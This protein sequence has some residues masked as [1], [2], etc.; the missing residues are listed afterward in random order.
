MGGINARQG[1]EMRR[2]LFNPATGD[3]DVVF[4]SEE[5]SRH[6]S[7]VLRMLPGTEVELFDG[8]GTVFKAVILKTGSRVTARL[9]QC[10]GKKE[11]QLKPVWVAQGLLKGKKM[12]MVVQKC[13]ELGATRFTPFVSSRC[14]GKLVRVQSS[15]RLERWQ[16][17]TIAACKQCMRNQ[18]ML[19]DETLAFADL[20]EL[21]EVA[22]SPLRLLFW[23][24]ETVTRLDDLPSFAQFNSICLILGPE[25]GLTEEEVEMAKIKGWRTVTLGE[26]ILRA[27]TA[28]LSA[29]SIVQ[30]L[31]GNI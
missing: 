4:L 23:E 28:N 13:T 29:V 24:E 22:P 30:Y 1:Y 20:L 5:E 6:I 19:V 3:G 25:G 2:F 9:G 17:L 15:R 16:R 12:D 8:A 27:E 21:Y 11:I 18:P 31:A 7:R 10:L 14:Q 26:R